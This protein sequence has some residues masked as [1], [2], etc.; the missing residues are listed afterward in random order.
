MTDA[1]GPQKDSIAGN[2]LRYTSSNIFQ[3]LLGL[4]T[5]LIRPRLLSPNLYGVFNLLNV[6]PTYFS[7][8][9]LGSYDI[10]RYRVPYHEARGEHEVSLDIQAG[11]YYGSLLI[12][13]V[14]TCAMIV[15]ALVGD[16]TPVI[17]SGL[18][19]TALVVMVQ[20]YHDNY[21]LILKARQNFARLSASI[22]VQAVSTLAATAVLTYFFGLAGAL[23]AG[24]LALVPVL[25]YLRVCAPIGKK[26]RFN[27]NVFF[28]LIRDGFPIMVYNFAVVLLNTSDRLVISYLLG[29]EQLGYYGVA[30]MVHSFLRQI[31]GRAREVLEPRLMRSVSHQS[32]EEILREYLFKPLLTT[33]FLMPLLIGPAVFLLPVVIPLLLPKYIPGILATQIIV[34][35][36]Y[37]LAL[38]YVTRGIFVAY[39]WQRT[40]AVFMVAALLFNITLSVGF[41]KA[42]LGIAGVAAAAGISQLVLLLICLSYLRVKCDSAATPWRSTLVGVCLPLIAMGAS[43]AILQIASAATNLGPIAGALLKVA[44][45]TVSSLGTIA[46]AK[47][48]FLLLE[49][50]S[51]HSL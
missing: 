44:L 28:S 26:S 50:I 19:I 11:V 15:V 30:I 6:I 46:L 12:N 10:T 41:V 14:L 8:S 43:I 2:V 5:A 17:R 42:G 18:L 34:C 16:F 3:H 33:A 51:V 48:R 49:G 45:F 36:C 38:S 21:V 40:G 9:N 22:Y 20:W 24:V 27:R 35:G 4:V 32:R 13:A 7:Y 47:R 23:A 25:I 1:R 29:N 37:F 31:P 39:N